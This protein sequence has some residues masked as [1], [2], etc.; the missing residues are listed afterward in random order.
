MAPCYSLE[1]ARTCGVLKGA[2]CAFGVFDG[3]HR[4][5]QFII[6]QA[7]TSARETGAS[8]LVITFDRDP[9]EL[10]APKV[11]HKLQSNTQRLA[12]LTQSGV[13]AVCV[14]PFDK[15]F[16]SQSPEDFLA[17]TFSSCEPAHLHVGCDFRFGA[18]ARGDI[19]TLKQW[20]ATCDCAVHAHDLY[21]ADGAPITST[22][23]RHLL[24]EGNIREANALL[25]HAYSL[26]GCVIEGRKQGRDFGFPTANIQASSQMHALADGVYAAYA[27]VGNVVR[28]AAVSLGES[29]L[30]AHK[31]AAS[32]EVHILDFDGN[33]Y[34]H[35]LQVRFYERIRGMI[36][37]EDVDQLKTT[38]RDNIAWVR[39]NMP[40]EEKDAS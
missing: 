33:L 26:E 30:F 29:P 37:F 18:Q 14:I 6:E 20:G 32:C 28:R 39:D 1:E 2:S 21:V 16:A 8:S 7:C 3:L 11:L 22:R 10:F 38:V 19:A 35:E 27:Q 17:A 36:A 5:H 9:D 34:G 40:Q 24:T 23:I 25:G 12:S 4:G 13:D 15:D 31:G